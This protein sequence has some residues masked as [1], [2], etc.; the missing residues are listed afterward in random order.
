MKENEDISNVR[1]DLERVSGNEELQELAR[2]RELRE[3]DY[4]TFEKNKVKC[5]RKEGF[6]MGIAEGRKEGFEQGVEE[7]IAKGS[8]EKSKEIAKEMLKDGMPIDKVIKFTHLTKEEV[9]SLI[10]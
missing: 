8:T 2:L 4:I 9:E 7:G 10:S 6:E 1:E 5:A 3:H